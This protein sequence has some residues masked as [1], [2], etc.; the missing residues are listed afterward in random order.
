MVR[1]II[2][3]FIICKKYEGAPFRSPGPPPPLQE[4]R[5]K[6]DPAFTHSGVDFA[7]LLDV[8]STTKDRRKV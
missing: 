1:A 6:E 2:H 3:R 7:G 5:V 4:F 8:N